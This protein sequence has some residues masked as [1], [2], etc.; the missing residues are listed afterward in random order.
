M[1]HHFDRR[2]RRRIWHLA[3]YFHCCISLCA[4]W[5]MLACHRHHHQEWCLL[6][7][8]HWDHLC[9]WCQPA[10]CHITCR[11]CETVPEKGCIVALHSYQCCIH[12]CH[13]G[14]VTL[15][16]ILL[17]KLIC[18]ICFFYWE[19]VKHLAGKIV[20][21]FVWCCSSLWLLIQ[22]LLLLL[23]WQELGAWGYNI[24]RLIFC[25][26]APRT[27]LKFPSVPSHAHV[28]W[29]YNISVFYSKFYLAYFKRLILSLL[30][31][32]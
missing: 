24:H 6:H 32:Y 12:V 8:S 22:L 4:Q 23:M 9:H 31:R 28:F 15:A 26:F 10:L 13:E 3:V 29:H 16:F 5:C 7:Q 25:H 1:L 20:L 18:L 14:D 27:L 11:L 17:L 2:R 21:L 19:R 30:E